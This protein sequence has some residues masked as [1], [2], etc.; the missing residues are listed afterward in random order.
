[1]ASYRESP[2]PKASQA[3]KDAAPKAPDSATPERARQVC[4]EISTDPDHTPHAGAVPSAVLESQLE[5]DVARF[6]ESLR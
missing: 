6:L 1:M 5:V 2:P 3:I 4:E